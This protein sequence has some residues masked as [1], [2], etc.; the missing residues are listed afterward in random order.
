MCY[1]KLKKAKLEKN[2]AKAAIE[3]AQTLLKKGVRKKIK[4]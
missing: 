1:N 2:L 4:K 3:N